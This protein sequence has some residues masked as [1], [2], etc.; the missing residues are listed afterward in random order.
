M[1]EPLF[2][3]AWYRV[4]SL[5]PRLRAQVEI[6]R[7]RYRG[8]TSYVLRDRASGRH[9]HVSPRGYAVVGLLNGARSVQEAWETAAAQ[10]GDEVPTQG[11]VIDLLAHLHGADL[12]RCDVPPATAELFE[13]YQHRQRQAL[14]RGLLSPLAWRIPLLDPQRI[15]DWMVPWVRPALGWVGALLWLAVVG[16]A[17][18]LAALHW[19]ELTEGLAARVLDPHS[20]LLLA[21]L[22]PPV[23]AVHELA[24]GVVTRAWGGE[25]HEAGI[26]V[27]VLMPLPY[28][29]ASSASAFPDKRRRMT[30][31]AAGIGAELLLSAI[32]LYVWLAVEPGLVSSAAYTVMLI[33]GASTLLFNG[34]PLLR[35]DGYYVLADALE[36]PNLGRRA[37]QYLAYLLQRY[38]LGVGHARSPGG[39]AGERA[40]LFT[41]GLAST[42]YRVFIAFAIALFVASELPAV[43]IALALW[44]LAAQIAVPIARGLHFALTSPILRRRR[45]RALATGV[46]ATVI[47]GTLIFRVPLPSAT[48]VEGVVRVPEEA[49]VRAGSDGFV[50]RVLVAPDTRVEA[51]EPLI[52]AEDPLLLTEVRVLAARQ[53][54]L[55][56]KFTAS[57]RVDRREAQA[58]KD[59]LTA[60][61]AELRRAQE[62][63]DGLLVRSPGAGRLIVPEASDLPGRYVRQGEVL[64][65][66][67]ESGELTARVV[68]PQDDVAL[69]RQRSHAVEVKVADRPRETLRARVVREVPAA[70]DRLPSAMLGTV[71]GGAIAVDPAQADGTRALQTVFKF[72][73]TLPRDL[74]AVPIGARVYARF[75]HGREPLAEQWARRL[76]QLLLE[77]LAV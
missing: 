70:D 29:D 15:L 77:R 28:V 51:G 21:L 50:R 30:V 20:L 68:V 48:R 71:G 74:Q 62:R 1:T 61:E 39:G 40:W 38:G 31:G 66:V 19:P 13:R 73:L 42:A 69:V 27:L 6:H 12:L 14:A 52:E 24:H 41:Y 32:A 45:L 23:K 67:L 37:Q 5:R 76:Q 22:Y 4:A 58:V 35:F 18:V 33:G 34:N 25:V 44:A 16:P 64:G 59:D 8:E 26:M 56:A 47:F 17:A 60:V 7:H 36:I 3:E 63:L 49:F 43:G 57:L 10:L 53:A 55:R 75:D 65:Y 72:D 46:L 9:H 54:E 2:S 11:Q